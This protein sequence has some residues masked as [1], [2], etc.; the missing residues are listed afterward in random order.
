MS[1][2]P[3]TMRQLL[4]VLLAA[5]LSPAIRVLP[6]GAARAAG[7]AGW[8]SPLLA[9]PIALALCWVLF[10]VLAALPP[11][12]GLA[13]ACPLVLGKAGGKLALAL[14]LLWGLLQ[15]SVTVRMC[16]QRF[17]ITGYRNRP[18]VFYMVVLLAVALWMARGRLAALG[19]AGEVF[20][21]VLAVT[22]GVVLLLAAFQMEPENLFPIW[23][24]DLPAA[25]AAVVPVL[26]LVG[27]AVPGAFLAGGLRRQEGDRAGALRWTA[28][29]CLLLSA[30]LLVALGCLGPDL[31]ARVEQPFF[32]MVKGIGVQGAFQRVE[33]V[34]MALWVLSDLMLIGMLVLAACAVSRALFGLKRA[35]S[36]ALPVV[37]AA[38]AGSVLLF[39]D[40]FAVARFADGILTAGNLAFG[41]GLPLLLLA[42]G[43]MRGKCV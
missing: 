10:Q 29:L 11:G 37:L 41:F 27:Y 20:R 15:L 6:G 25:G 12:T 13:E 24:E 26:S 18:V 21:T 2:T 43:K 3:I 1:D 30:L 31:I 7:E 17:L 33:S 40:A 22:L 35:Q 16:G 34:V 8:L 9:L 19:R 36:A 28:R 32:V 39:R 38:L 5:L 14:C 42:V 23:T 4:S